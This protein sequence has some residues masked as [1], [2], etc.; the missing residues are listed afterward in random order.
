MISG[1]E[2][3]RPLTSLLPMTFPVGLST[4]TGPCWWA[5]AE[6][7]KSTFAVNG[8]YVF[9]VIHVN[10]LGTF[11][12]F[13]FRSLRRTIR[14]RISGERRQLGDGRRRIRK[15]DDLQVQ[16]ISRDAQCP[17]PLIQSSVESLL[18]PALSHSV[19]P[20]KAFSPE[21]T[22]IMIPAQ[23]KYS[24]I[25]QSRTVGLRY[26]VL[27]GVCKFSTFISNTIQYGNA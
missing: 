27:S 21:R 22:K 16:N 6:A 11:L 20:T 2:A 7:P 12:S 1:P 8:F 23:S 26:G 15:W 14:H 4:R 17:I 9:R 24:R 19:I 3:C 25:W 5:I 13:L 18:F 10:V